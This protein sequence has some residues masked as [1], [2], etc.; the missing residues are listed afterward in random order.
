MNRFHS[1]LAAMMVL[2]AVVMAGCSNKAGHGEHEE[3]STNLTESRGEHDRD[4]GE[5]DAEGQSEQGGGEEG[6]ELGTFYSLAHTYDRTRNGARLILAY[7]AESN[8]FAGTVENTTTET[9]ERVRVEVHLSNGKELGP[10]TPV[11]LKPGE[12]TDVRLAATSKDFDAWNAHPEVGSGEHGHEG[13]E[14]GEHGGEGGEHDGEGGEHDRE[15]GEHGGE[16]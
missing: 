3:D 15:S 2:V 8:A 11:D 1:I 10:T 7:D 6:E 5:H 13:G 16:G 4:G 12:K 9:L 14:G